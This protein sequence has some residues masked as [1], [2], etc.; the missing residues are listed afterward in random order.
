MKETFV[1]TIQDYGIRMKRLL[2]MLVVILSSFIL[3]QRL[4]LRISLRMV[5]DNMGDERLIAIGD[6][7][8]CFHTLKELLKKVDYSSTTDTLVFVGDYIDRGLFSYEMVDF[9]IKLQRQ[10]R[11]DKVICLKGNH[12]VM[13][14]GNDYGLWMYNGGQY[15][16]ASYERNGY[17][18]SIHR[19]WMRN[20]PLI[21]DTPNIIFC[22]AG[23]PK[24]VLEQNTEQDIVW[25][26]E[27]IDKIYNTVRRLF[28]RVESVFNIRHKLVR[29][30]CLE[31]KQ[32]IFFTGIL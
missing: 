28:K 27:W 12:E 15:T 1:F 31:R 29:L 10:V 30:M 25:D 23:L 32:L 19:N 13:A 20:L 3:Y 4:I 14:I 17:D 6:I 21:Y 26:R 7:H 8:G 9:L 16:V 24:P 18:V 5:G 11:K 22:H 2:L